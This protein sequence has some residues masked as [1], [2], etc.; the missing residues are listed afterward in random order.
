MPDETPSPPPEAPKSQT[1]Q[2]LAMAFGFATSA[3]CIVLLALEKKLGFEE[4][5]HTALVGTITAST[6]AGG[7]GALL[8]QRSAK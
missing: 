3:L 7:I 8:F 4:S 5:T 1:V 2:I 6:A